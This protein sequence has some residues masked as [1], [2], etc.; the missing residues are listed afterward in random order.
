MEKHTKDKLIGVIVTM[1]SSA[2]MFMTY[3]FFGSFETKAS[4][5]NKYQILSKKID[6]VLCYM[7]KK[8][9]FKKD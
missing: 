9:C 6:L 7:D 5:E 4:S 2:M 3:T 8:Y 1:V